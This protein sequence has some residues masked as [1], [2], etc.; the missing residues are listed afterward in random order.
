[1]TSP[2]SVRP[3]GATARSSASVGS[4][5]VGGAHLLLVEDDSTVREAVAG[6]LAAHGYRIAQAPDAA[7]A[8]RRWDA[9]RPDVILLDLGLPDADGTTIIRRVRRE[10]TTPILVLSARGSEP[11]KVAALE[12]GADD[13]VTKPFGLAELRA[14]V[15]ALLRRTAGPTADPSGTIRHGPLRIDV[16][17]RIATVDGVAL[18]L[19]P[20]EY[21]LLRTMVAQPG[22]LLTKAR[23]LRA[24][25]GTAYADEAHYLHVY[26]SRLRRKLA[27]ADRDGSIRDL[28]VA[29]PGVGYRIAE[30]PDPE[31]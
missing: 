18:D 24:V 26:V 5:D 9:E 25:W 23:L 15:A 29:E 31:G 13:Y 28:I 27:A 20:R 2:D 19:T 14:R 21:E 12:A 7:E 10:A 6:N 17:R 11:D 16:T 8:L 1:M 30:A 3:V 4:A 22:R